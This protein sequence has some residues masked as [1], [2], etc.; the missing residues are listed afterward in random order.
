MLVETPGGRRMVTRNSRQKQRERETEAG[1]GSPELKSGRE[2]AIE[3]ATAKAAEA[4]RS[5]RV[6]RGWN[7]DVGACGAQQR[8]KRQRGAAGQRALWTQLIQRN[9]VEKSVGGISDL[10]WFIITQYFVKQTKQIDRFFSS[11]ASLESGFQCYGW[12]TWLV[13]HANMHFRLP[14]G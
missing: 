3:E 4:G 14:V 7:L 13:E 10:Y 8:R 1:V 11:R 6:S 9:R 12:S 2:L 5:S